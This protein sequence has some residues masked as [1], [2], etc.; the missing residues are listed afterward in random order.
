MCRDAQIDEKV[1][2]DN[3]IGYAARGVGDVQ[4]SAIEALHRFEKKPWIIEHLSDF[5]QIEATSSI[6]ILSWV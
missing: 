5:S 3:V 2:F 4:T 1:F 6:P